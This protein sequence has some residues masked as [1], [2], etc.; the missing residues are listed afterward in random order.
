MTNI[1]KE[2]AEAAVKTLLQYIG[3]DTDRQGL[4][5]TPKRVVNS[6][7]E[8]F[9]GYKG[10]VAKVLS[11][12]FEDPKDYSGPILLRDIK[13]TSVCEHHMLPFSG[14]VDIAYIPDK[15][16]IGISKLA[17]LVDIYAKRL[18]IQE[19]MTVQIA[20]SLY[21]HLKPKAV[22]VKVS[23]K[24]TCMVFRGVMKDDNYLET[25]HFLGDYSEDRQ[26]Q[27]Q[28]WRMIK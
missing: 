11:K 20:R 25:S 26:L 27:E 13:F 12:Q 6:Y 21:E 15:G 1:S 22:A 8:L 3:E 5:D 17:R 9:S 14:R 18:Q 19:K 24:H 4:H 7:S 23:A 16:V 2:Q 10:D 28:F